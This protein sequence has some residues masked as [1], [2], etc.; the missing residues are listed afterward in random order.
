[1]ITVSLVNIHSHIQLQNFLTMRISKIHSLSNF[2]TPF[3]YL[4]SLAS[5]FWI[6]EHIN[7]GSQALPGMPP[8]CSRGLL[9]GKLYLLPE[10][11]SIILSNFGQVS[12][13][14]HWIGDLLQFI[15]RAFHWHGQQRS[16]A[17]DPLVLCLQRPVW[18]GLGAALRVG[19]CF[20]TPTGVL[21]AIA[22]QAAPTP[23]WG[24]PPPRPLGVKQEVRASFPG[25]FPGA[26]GWARLLETP[27]ASEM[28]RKWLQWVLVAC[29]R[30]VMGQKEGP[31][32]QTF[33]GIH[34]S[35]QPGAEIP[36]SL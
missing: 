5:T 10:S 2:Q 18:I 28:S 12:L 17:E 16:K 19:G 34:V 21:H 7:N 23:S 31:L 11:C 13:S 25:L 26:Q 4:G 24:P 27:Q 15:T 33:L 9:V 29:H 1:M 22:M 36:R 8:T 20:S 6:S 3:A 35:Q 30:P 32:C 14:D